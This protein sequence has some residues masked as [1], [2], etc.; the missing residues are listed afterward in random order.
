M[1][2]ETVM[3]KWKGIYEQKLKKLRVIDQTKPA[4]MEFPLNYGNVGEEFR[5]KNWHSLY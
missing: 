1:L 5:I 4:A 2:K 3:T